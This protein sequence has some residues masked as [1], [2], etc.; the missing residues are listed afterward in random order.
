MDIFEDATPSPGNAPEFTVSEISGAVKRVIEGEFGHVRV[1]GE[2]SRVSRPA[3][4]HLY[5][6]LKDDRAVIAAVSWKGQA[7]RMSVRP[8]EG[9]E[10]IA[11]GRLTTFPGQSKY[12]LIVEDIVPAGAGALMMML[13]KLKARLAA[14]GLFA[15]DRKKPIPYLPEVI[16][17]VTS[18]SGAVIRDILHRLRDRFP[19]RVLI[20]PVAVQGEKCAPEVAAAIRGFNALQKGGPIPRPDLLI[21]AR[22]GGSIEDLWG[23]N[24]EQVVRAAAG[25]A[26]PLI[27]AVGH[28]TDT[29]L[30]DHA[31]DRR[32]P[33]PTAA[34]EMAVPVRMEL[35]AWTQEQSA[36][37]ARAT[38]QRLDQRQQRLSDLARGLGRPEALTG[39]ARQRLD[40][41]SDRLPGALRQA[42][43]AK[44]TALTRISARV[45]PPLLTRFIE[46]ER[47][48][49]GQLSARLAPA[50]R[51]RL[52]DETKDAR[53]RRA[54]LARFGQALDRAVSARLAALLDHL[55]ALDRTRQT[56][57]YRET[58]RRGFAV[59]RADDRIVTS[60]AVAEGATHLEIEFQD[61]R[62]ATGARPKAGSRKPPP[63]DQGTLF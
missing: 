15:A 40:L 56:L 54:D 55:S 13:E 3:S 28:E 49:L 47:R 26:I 57:G 4:G 32:A 38:R 61:G 10:V 6:D 36:R 59:V 41:W 48:H 9:M 60:R 8:E 16:G 1:R 52:E 23:F 46:A 18:P 29:T 17:V 62:I 53:Q 27:S 50:L 35:L 19:R 22:G 5:F 21:V 45:Q 31:A 39:N 12:Q 63:P 11:T 42:A 2:I 20:W 33:T 7:A 30:I 25:S 14:E 34:A 24:D 51:R 43:L 44:R 58:L 37:L